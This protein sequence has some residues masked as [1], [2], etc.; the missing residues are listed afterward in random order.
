MDKKYMNTTYG[1]FWFD[2]RPVVRD[3]TRSESYMAAAEKLAWRYNVDRLHIFKTP[4]EAEFLWM[5]RNTDILRYLI[6]ND[7]QYVFVGG[8]DDPSGKGDYEEELL[9]SV[10]DRSFIPEPPGLKDGTSLFIGEFDFVKPV[11]SGAGHFHRELTNYLDICEDDF[12]I[13]DDYLSQ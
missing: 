10:V 1:R 6:D 9:F 8:S 7:I 12:E 2:S 3:K 13:N 11:R 5:V 4:N